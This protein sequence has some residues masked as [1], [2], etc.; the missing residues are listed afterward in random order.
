MWRECLIALKEDGYMLRANDDIEETSFDI[1]LD[2]FWAMVDRNQSGDYVCN[3]SYLDNEGYRMSEK[4][5]F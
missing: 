2:D 3:D 4:Y 1:H 5:T